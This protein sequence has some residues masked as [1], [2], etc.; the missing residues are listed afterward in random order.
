MEAEYFETLESV[1]QFVDCAKMTPA[2]VCVTS[3]AILEKAFLLS[4]PCITLPSR[5]IQGWVDFHLERGIFNLWT[6]QWLDCVH[7]EKGTIGWYRSE[8]P[9]MVQSV[10]ILL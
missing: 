2:F 7:F 8:K 4:V 1:N 6:L 9:K 3:V 5:R 10:H